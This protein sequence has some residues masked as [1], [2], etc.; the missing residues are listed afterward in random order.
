[1]LYLVSLLPPL[2]LIALLFWLD[3]FS[4]VGKST[5]LLCFVW[6]ILS[7]LIAGSLNGL[8][9]G[10]QLVAPPIIEETIK[11]LGV[12]WLVR[13]RRSAF[14]IDSALYGVTV[15]AGFAFLENIG[16]L[17]AYPDM[18]LG[19]ALLRGMGTAIMHCGAVASTAVLLCHVMQRRGH[20][21]RWYPLALLPAIGLHVFYN[22]LILPPMLAL[23]L[24]CLGVTVLLGL[25]FLSNEKSIGNWMER[26][27]AWEVSMLSAMRRGEFAASRTGEYLLS[28]RERFEPETFMDIYCCLRTYLEL[29]VCA[30]RNM[31]LAEAGL[32]APDDD[33]RALV[34]EFRH[35]YRAIGHAGRSVL[36]PLI[37]RDKLTWM[38]KTLG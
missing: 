38:L 5:L 33:S 6:G 27:L 12:L 29:S 1:M 21:V 24:V 20:A 22:S 13:M 26:E 31:M 16:Y 37:R 30:K 10:A 9:T 17:A 11:G 25:L 34:A 32:A 19:T 23:P 36:T 28:A 4:L 8:F 35:T 14:F 7:A 18:L 3:S 15:G 2:L